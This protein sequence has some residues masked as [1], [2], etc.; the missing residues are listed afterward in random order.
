[1]VTFTC[2]YTKITLVFS[3]SDRGPHIEFKILLLHCK[4]D[5]NQIKALTT[6]THYIFQA[7]SLHE[8]DK[9]KYQKTGSSAG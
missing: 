6:E 5:L 4:Y 8:G 7:F 9:I 3:F 2:N 1:M